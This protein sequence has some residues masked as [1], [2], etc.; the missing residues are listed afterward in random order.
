M[1]RW[2]GLRVPMWFLIPGLGDSNVVPDARYLRTIA[3][4]HRCGAVV[5]SMCSGAF[6]L[7][8]TGLLNGQTATTHW[9]LA[10]AL[11]E[12]YPEVNV[13]PTVLFVG[14][15]H[16]TSAGVAAGIDLSI[17]LIRLFF[18]SQVA[19]TVSR[20][21]VSGTAPDGW[22]GFMR[23]PVAVKDPDGVALDVVRPCW[24]PIRGKRGR[25]QILPKTRACPSAPSFGGSWPRQERRPISG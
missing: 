12:R 20:S 15:P 22:P 19:A 4:A 6:V 3:E 17:H 5:A 11:A 9:A 16:P 18:G 14:R 23:S 2:F 10:D 8:E 21:M 7:A 1:R 24:Q 25:W 13:D